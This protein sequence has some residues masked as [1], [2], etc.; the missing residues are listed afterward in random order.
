MRV[1]LNL[2]QCFAR[3]VQVTLVPLFGVLTEDGSQVNGV[4]DLAFKE[5][6]PNMIDGVLVECG[7]R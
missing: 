1:L 2:Q 3:A 7:I 5:G 6:L 4:V